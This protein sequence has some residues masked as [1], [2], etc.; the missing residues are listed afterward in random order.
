MLPNFAIIMM[1]IDIVVFKVSVNLE[2]N[3]SLEQI[4][5]MR[6]DI[7]LLYHKKV[8]DIIPKSNKMY[9]NM[10]ML[11]LELSLNQACLVLEKMLKQNMLKEMLL[12]A[13]DLMNP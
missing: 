1:T 6:V 4:F 13:T 12:Q 3:S 2:K 11:S 8:L 7:T 10:L 5:V 9:M